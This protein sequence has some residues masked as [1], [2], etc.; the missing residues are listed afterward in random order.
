MDSFEV[1]EGYIPGSLG[2][3]ASLHGSYYHEHWGFGVYFEAK[4]A[5]E[6]AS[7]LTAY[8]PGRDGFWTA[9][10]DGQV[11]ASIVIDGSDAY[12][13]GAHLRW[14][15][16]SDRLRSKGAGR[17]LLGT[18]MRFCRERQYPA[19]YL[20][21]F[22][23]L[24]AARHLYEREGFALS[25]ERPGTTWGVEVLEQRFECLLPSST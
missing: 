17:E 19:V 9:S 21:T 5:T 22:G 6:L 7:F 24:D 13:K 1:V 4:V 10:V 2:R 12:G 15:I 18:A 8:V 23:G 3:S 16:V 25:E 11:E 14:F 20:W